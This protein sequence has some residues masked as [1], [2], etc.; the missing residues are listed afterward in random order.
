MDSTHVAIGT[1]NVE[2]PNPLNVPKTSL[3]KARI[4]RTPS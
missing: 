4:K 3:K 1:K 2:D